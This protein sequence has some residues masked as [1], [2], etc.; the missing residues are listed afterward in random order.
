MRR[1]EL[2]Q[3]LASRLLISRRFGDRI[4]EIVLDE[5]SAALGDGE[6][7]DLFHFG[8][9]KVATWKARTIPTFS[10]KP[11][12][13]PARKCVKFKAAAALKERVRRSAKSRTKN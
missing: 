8:E 6:K 5:I 13:I 10:G 3:A 7:V 4:V 2:S 11:K 12:R 1:C 9:F